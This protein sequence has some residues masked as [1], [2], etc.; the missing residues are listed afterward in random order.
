MGIMGKD[1]ILGV[2]DLKRE[3]VAVPE[4]GGE[5]IIQEITAYDRDALFREINEG[6]TV[7]IA[8]RVLVRCL[9]DQNGERLFLDEEAGRLGQ[10]STAV[11][12]RLF[13]VAQRLNAINGDPE[14]AVKN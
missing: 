10:R 9:V 3:T 7:N 11:L 8:A 14:E 6:S 12:N 1:A 13:E 2:K 4:W 5:V